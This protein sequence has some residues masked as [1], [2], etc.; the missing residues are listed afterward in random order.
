MDDF[1]SLDTPGTPGVTQELAKSVTVVK[2]QGISL[3]KLE[4]IDFVLFIE[5]CLFIVSGA[6]VGE[7]SKVF[8]LSLDE[9]LQ[10][11]LIVFLLMSGNLCYTLAVR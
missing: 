3:T 11:V 7:L 8:N 4:M 5:N 2:G 9:C 6:W 10:T 1:A